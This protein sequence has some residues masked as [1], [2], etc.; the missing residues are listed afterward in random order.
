MGSTSISISTRPSTDTCCWQEEEEEGVLLVAFMLCAHEGA[1]LHAGRL[2]YQAGGS[3]CRVLFFLF[4]QLLP[5]SSGQNW[6]QFLQSAFLSFW[7]TVAMIKRPSALW[8][9]RVTSA[10]LP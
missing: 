1:A 8:N 4:G 9:S 10:T 7:A 2:V 3:F 6:W 5:W